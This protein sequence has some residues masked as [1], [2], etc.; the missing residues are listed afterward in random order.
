M[1]GIQVTLMYLDFHIFGKLDLVFFLNRISGVGQECG[2]EICV[3]RCS[4]H[5]IVIDVFTSFES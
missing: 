5:E 2:S 3:F 1:Y 4:L